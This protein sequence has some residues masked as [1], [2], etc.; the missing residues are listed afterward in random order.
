MYDGI[1]NRQTLTKNSLSAEGESFEHIWAGSDSR[2]EEDCKFAG[3]LGF[4]DLGGFD[5]TLESIQRRDGTV[6]LTSTYWNSCQN[7]YGP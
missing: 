7:A 4:S 5:D 6:Y 1:E 3:L 2:I